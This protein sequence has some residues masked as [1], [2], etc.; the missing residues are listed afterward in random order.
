[1]FP[2]A[3]V[4]ATCHR[5]YQ[6]R[7]SKVFRNHQQ[8]DPDFENREA[9]GSLPGDGACK[10][11]LMWVAPCEFSSASEHHRKG[12]DPSTPFVSQ[13]ARDKFRSG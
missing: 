1:V 3:V 2:S 8:E 11:Q 6:R 7:L 10:C 13:E 5:F 12:S 4:R 9:W